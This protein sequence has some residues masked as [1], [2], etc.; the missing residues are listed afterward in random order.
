MAR[1]GRRAAHLLIGALLAGWLATLPSAPSQAESWSPVAPGV[2]Y[3]LFT[4]PGPRRVHVARLKIASPDVIIESAIA[5]GELSQGIETVGAMARRYD[6][7][8][9]A[10][11]GQWGPR[12]RVLVAI[13]GSSFDAETGEPYGGLFH[14]G[15]YGLRYGDV[16]GGTGFV[17]TSDRRAVIRGCVN[18]QAERQVVTRLADGTNAEIGAVNEAS[19]R[20]G[21]NLYT[22]SF[23]A[24][25]PEA[26]KVTEVI[27]RVDRPIGVAPLPNGALGTVVA[28]RE[29]GGATPLL[30]DQAV[31][32]ARGP[33]A[34]AFLKRLRPGEAVKISE[35][36][37]DLGFGCKTQ[38]GFDWTDA[39]AAIGGGFVFL[40]DGE[41]RE[42]DD[43]G[44]Y[45]RAPRTAV[46]L[47]EKYVYFVVADG[48]RDGSSIGMTFDDLGHFCQD[49]LDA[50]WGVNQDGGGSSTMW[51]EGKVVNTPSDGF[52]RLVANGLMMVQVQPPAHST[53]F[54]P[55]FEVRLQTSAE[56]RTGPGPTFPVL[57]T[58]ESGDEGQIEPVS[59]ALLG[60]FAAGSYWWKMDIA[61]HEGYV[62]EQA[63]VA[64]P[65]ALAW[66]RLPPP[67]LAIPTLQP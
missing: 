4:V 40:R 13:N 47:N 61:G 65:G 10:W 29:A 22:A 64:Q 52:E 36:I 56:L 8:L 24:A 50:T 32:N 6:G 19:R 49:D 2:D 45:A 41:I 35:E 67:V 51:I 37:T 18:H 57:Q 42:S 33:E 21:L 55:G 43:A 44:A 30:F 46:C 63:L 59:R 7:S 14:S 31:L 11:G 9:I 54:D 58:A 26:R 28:L 15:E 12:A 1:R 25:T 48:R 53:R 20:M 38:G 5:S 66:F 23:G 27:L 3:R 34:T 39:Y 62:P 16:A 60:I 17:W